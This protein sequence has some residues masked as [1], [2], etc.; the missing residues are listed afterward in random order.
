MPEFILARARSILELGGWNVYHARTDAVLGFVA[1]SRRVSPG[2]LTEYARGRLIQW[3]KHLINTK[4]IL[5]RKRQCPPRA[6]AAFFSDPPSLNGPVPGNSYGGAC[7]Q[8]ATGDP[9]V[10]ETAMSGAIWT[11]CLVPPKPGDSSVAAELIVVSVAVKEAM[12]HRILAAELRQGP[13]G[14]TPLYLD[15]LAVLHGT[16][17]DQ[18]SR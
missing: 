10:A 8:I 3:A 14:P 18:L 16:A 15:A 4:E 17:A 1:I 11:R 12:T 9:A 7:M 6:G 13:W 2:R 5:L